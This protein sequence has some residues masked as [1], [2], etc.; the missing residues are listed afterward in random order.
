MAPIWMIIAKF[1]PAPVK[2]DED[3]PLVLAQRA[4]NA[5]DAARVD[6]LIDGGASSP[7][8][9][10]PSEEF[11]E[12][13]RNPESSSTVDS[14]D[15]GDDGDPDDEIVAALAGIEDELEGG[16]PSTPPAP[17]PERSEMPVPAEIKRMNR[18]QLIDLCTTFGIAVPEEATKTDLRALLGV[19]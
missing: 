1:G 7:S 5:A 13:T 17:Q 18:S 19:E 10:P 14:E 9:P 16:E 8:S 15:D 4:Q 12:D 6:L 11:T 2:I 3:H